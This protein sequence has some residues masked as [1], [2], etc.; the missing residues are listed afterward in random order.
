MIDRTFA[1]VVIDNGNGQEAV[2]H[3]ANCADIRKN[4]RV[5]G[6][7]ATCDA[8]VLD[9]WSDFLPHEMSET[10]AIDATPRNGCTTDGKA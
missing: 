10:E 7:G 1:Y 2:A 4:D 8:A 3:R 5:I 9:S 6:R